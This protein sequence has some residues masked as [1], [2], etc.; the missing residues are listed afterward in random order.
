MMGKPARGQS[1]QGGRRWENQV[2]G[3][4]EEM[5]KGEEIEQKRNER[6]AKTWGER[7]EETL[8]SAG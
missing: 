4:T 6:K 5:N 3:M 7:Q 8:W 2:L 1:R